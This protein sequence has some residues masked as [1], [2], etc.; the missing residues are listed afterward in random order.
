MKLEIGQE[1][2]IQS[3]K[4]DGSLHRTWAKG[5]VIEVTNKQLVVVTNQST[6]T[7]ADGRRWITREPAI[8]YFYPDRFYNVICMI[9]KTGVYYYCNLASPCIYDGEALKN[10]DYDL[11]VKV[12]PEGN[13]K[14]LDEN[15]YALHQEEMNYPDELKI[16]IAR[17][18]DK[19]ISDITECNSPFLESEVNR[20]YLK[21]LNIIEEC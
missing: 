14:I 4:H 1:I 6:V 15:E 12:F 2:F 5:F 7:E 11:D 20:Q 16:K 21:Y 18:L 13:Y 17:T 19:L 3:F 10:I 8:C 9:R